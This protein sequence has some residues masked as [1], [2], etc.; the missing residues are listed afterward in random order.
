MNDRDLT[1]ELSDAC[2]ERRTCMARGDTETALLL[3]AWMDAL[4]DEWNRD[5]DSGPS[6]P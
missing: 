1:A 3:S 2:A 5:A 4:L 6:G